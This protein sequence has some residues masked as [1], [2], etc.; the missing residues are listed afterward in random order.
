[1]ADFDAQPGRTV[2]PVPYLSPT[3]REA[4]EAELYAGLRGVAG[5]VAGAQGVIDLLRDVAEFAAHAIPGADGVGVALIDPQ[6]GIS[7]VR[8]WAATAVLVHEIDTVQYDELKEGPCISCMQSRRPT[9]SGSLGSDNRWPHFGGRVA[10]MRMHSAL[11]L[12][13]IVGDEVIGSINAYAKSRDAFAEHAVL[14][15]SQFAKSAAVSIYN[16]QLLANAH[17]RTLR[18][19]RALNSRSVIDQ[20]I[21]IV[22]SRSG[23]SA[24]DAFERLTHISQSE[25]IKLYAVAERLVEEAVRRARARRR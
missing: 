24:D 15:G 5:I 7:S 1:M 22:R 9:L 11:A 10:R 20:A 13:L 16:A 25:N 18:L 19:Q 21:G 23:G 12:P 8:T 6:H 17:E 14:L 2:S 4:D 3:E